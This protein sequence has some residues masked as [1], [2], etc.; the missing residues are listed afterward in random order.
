MTCETQKIIEKWINMRRHRASEM[1]TF[2]ICRD[3][4][5]AKIIDEYSNTT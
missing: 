3:T 4:R 5:R 1:E 2:W